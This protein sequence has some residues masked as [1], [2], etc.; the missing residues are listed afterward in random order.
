MPAGEVSEIKAV[1]PD[2]NGGWYVG[3]NFT[4]LCYS[5]RTCY[6]RTDVAHIKA[7]KTV[8]PSFA[9]STNGSVRALA[10]SADGAT[11]YVGGAFSQAGGATARR[12]VAA[13]STVNGSPLPGTPMRTPR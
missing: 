13:F 1:L 6:T 11:L 10:L 3:G 4:K 9:P 12:N 8:D 5:T 2:G 7:D